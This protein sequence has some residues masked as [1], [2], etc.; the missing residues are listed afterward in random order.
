MKRFSL[1]SLLLVI[2]YFEVLFSGAIILTKDNIVDE[3]GNPFKSGSFVDLLF[4]GKNGY[5]ITQDGIY[6][7]FDNK[8]NIDIKNAQR[9]GLNYVLSGSK[10]Y[11]ILNNTATAIATV[12]SGLQNIYV[13]DDFVL[14]IEKWQV[15]CYYEGKVIWSLGTPVNSFKVS[16]NYLAAFGAQTLLINISNPQYLKLERMY[17]QFKDYAYFSDYHAFSDG[18]KIYIYKGASRL[19]VTFPYK[20]PLFS[21]GVNLYSGNL[22]INA[23][24]T[25]KELKFD[26][27]ALVPIPSGS[28][29]TTKTETTGS[30][31]GQDT[32]T[33]QSIG[34]ESYT[35]TTQQPSTESKEEQTSIIKP[36]EAKPTTKVLS[37][38]ELAW[39]VIINDQIS[40]KPAIKGDKLYIP[41]L[42]GA[43]ISISSGKIDW[44]Y[45][46]GFV[47]V[48]HVTVGNNVYVTSWDDTVYAINE[49]GTLN[50]KLKL[51]SDI[52]QGPAWDGYNLYV[53][54]D[55]GTLYIIRDEIR[56]AKIVSSYKTASYPVLPPSISLA[57]KIY[58]IDGLGNLW[59]DKT[60]AGYV[61][62][63]KN[64][65]ILYE[66]HYV[67][68]EL[69]FTL[70]DE[71]GINYQF[72]PLE[73]ETQIIKGKNLFV[74]I[75]DQ[76]VDAVLGKEFL[77]ALGNSGKLYVVDK[78]SRKIVFNDTI[79]GG[80][81]IG[82]S[83]GYLYV[84]GKEIRSYYMNDNPTGFWNSIYANQFN[85]NSAVK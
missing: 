21:D 52:S 22:M 51:D 84:F 80:K 59:R 78:D 26:V 75:S 79:P 56:S 73:R 76:I 66:N 9:V 61:G 67:T 72:I 62:K 53:V 34:T 57:G 45:K 39:K 13:K 68:Q 82:L 31:V 24:L 71:V 49:N 85:W 23:N 37:R 30:S 6:P 7:L 44:T 27:R 38:F 64:L 11:R 17:P 81:Y 58:V 48:G 1:F 25:Q 42:K 55:N 74:T 33:T 83:N 70:I 18:S 29:T 69:G 63:V 32:I 12:S 20:G 47:V 41:L 28:T 14:G 2:F 54:T 50:W 43:V 36:V 3:V 40:G 16:G 46:T 35:Q 77:Y 4:D 15:T 19:S 8:T 5:Y 60:T 10:I 65:P